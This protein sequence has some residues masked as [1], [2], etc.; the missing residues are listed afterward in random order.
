MN[1]ARSL[2]PMR[3]AGWCAVLLVSRSTGRVKGPRENPVAAT[4][5]LLEIIQKNPGA[6][7]NDV[8]KAFGKG[9]GGFYP[10]L[11]RL[12]KAKLV[13]T[14]R[15]GLTTHLF[16]ADAE[17][18][19]RLPAPDTFQGV[20]VEI[21]RFIAREPGLSAPELRDRLKIPERTVYRHLTALVEGGFVR[22]EKDG[23]RKGGFHPTRKLLDRL[24]AET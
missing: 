23:R 5:R 1:S 17:V 15:Q 24:K 7:T 13:Q 9:W 11:Q 14:R 8:H 18:P 4:L 2:W 3:L 22:T 6:S 19:R 12:K 20:R 10:Y 21:A 16:P